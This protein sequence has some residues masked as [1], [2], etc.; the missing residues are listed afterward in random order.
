MKEKLIRL[1]WWKHLFFFLAMPEL[2]FCALIEKN[3]LQKQKEEEVEKATFRNFKMEI[4]AG[5]FGNTT[6][7]IQREK[8]LTDE[9]MELAYKDFRQS[10]SIPDLQNLRST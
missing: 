8:P 6:Y 4:K 5:F 3:P 7:L 10:K 9:E 2:Y 1:K